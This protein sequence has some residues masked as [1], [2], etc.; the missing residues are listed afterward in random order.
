MKQ[1][2]DRCVDVTLGSLDLSTKWL[3]EE[4]LRYG[5]SNGLRSAL[6]PKATVGLITSIPTSVISAVVRTQDSN[7]WNGSLRYFGMSD[8]DM[9]ESSR[10]ERRFLRRVLSIN[11]AD[12]LRL[13]SFRPYRWCIRGRTLRTGANERVNLS[14][15]NPSLDGSEYEG[16]SE[17]CDQ[18]PPS[19]EQVQEVLA[20]STLP[21]PPG[22]SIVSGV[23]RPSETRYENVTIVDERWKRRRLERLRLIVLQGFDN[24]S[25]LMYWPIGMEGSTEFLDCAIE[26]KMNVIL[27]EERG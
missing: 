21:F 6:V 3:R 22:V 16:W 10:R 23:S 18:G 25:L 12:E 9:A 4:L 27:P 19:D 5:C 14:S 26:A 13:Y 24:D 2:I 17:H 8:D 1:H 20:Y 11:R 7:A 15:I